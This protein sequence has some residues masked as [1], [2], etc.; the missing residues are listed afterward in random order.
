MSVTSTLLEEVL[1]AAVR[2][3][4]LIAVG[5]DK[6]PWFSWK[7]YQEQAADQTQLLSWSRD[8]RCT[9]FAVITGAI[10]GFVVLDFD[11]G[12]VGLLDEHGLEAHVR[13]GRGG[14]HLRVE[15]PGFHIATQNSKV[16]KLL[17]AWWPG[18]DIR[19]DGGYAIEYGRSEHGGYQHLRD[20]SDL[21]PI[22]V[23]PEE[24]A[25]AL[26][27]LGE[28]ALD[29]L[30]SEESDANGKAKRS[31][32]GKFHTGHRHRHLLRIAG[33]MAGR[34][35]TE[36][37]ILAELRRVNAADCVPP[38]DDGQLAELA[39]DVAQRYRK[40]PTP[41]DQAER[42]DHQRLEQLLRLAQNG[43][44]VNDVRLIGNGTTAAVEIDLSNG[45]TLESEKFGDLWTHTG[46]AKFVTQG[47]GINA[48]GITKTDA[49]EANA[50]IRRLAKCR[51]ATTIRDLGCG[52]GVDFLARA[53]VETVDINDQAARYQ[54]WSRLQAHDPIR[55]SDPRLYDR[56]SDQPIPATVADCSIVL[57]HV[58]GRRLVRCAWL[59]A[60]V[61]RNGEVAHPGELARRMEHAGW[62]RPNKRGQM[63]AT[64]PG[65][66]APIRL[67]FWVVPAGW[68]ESL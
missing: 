41:T 10:S 50:I 59:F 6:R 63:K 60:H 1:E 44:H 8:Q 39:H 25:A 13:T 34:G 12:G 32:D 9:A 48:G 62:T 17:A 55:A 53:V 5:L 47:S 19:G 35:R 2:G 66:G 28:D 61:R 36:E 16:T 42:E 54:A 27:L 38:K 65:L 4:S 18:L 68:E 22:G 57:E 33:A 26:G 21:E 20:L 51:Y 58:D 29:E 37:E 3:E 46:L 11:E 67:D 64:S 45:E 49:A 31:S 7:R 23:L 15:H 56:Y 14:Y 43:V 24:M 30:T 52:H 40:A